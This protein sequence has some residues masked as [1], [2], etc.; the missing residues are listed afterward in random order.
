MALSTNEQVRYWGIGAVVFLLCLWV[1]GNVLLPFIT[2]MA[3]A[4]FL[5]PVADRLEAAGLSR[6]VATTVITLVAVVVILILLIVLIPLLVRQTA[7]FVSALPE[8]V[9][10]LQT[11]IKERFPEAFKEGSAVLQGLNS[12]IEFVRS[13]GGDLANAL[14]ASAFTIVDVAIF[15]VVA[16]VVAFYM[17]LDWDRMIA[18]IDGWIPRDHLETVRDLARQVDNVLAGFVR[19][20]LTVCSILGAFYAVA[21]MLVGLQFGVVVGLIAGLLTF[22]PYVGSIIG[23]VLSIGLALFQFW[24]DPIWIVAVLV[25]FVIGQMLEGNFLTPK[26][27]G[28]SVGL[29][30]VWLMFALS[31]FGS[32]LGF[33]GM[34]IAVPVAAML[35]VFF[36]FGVSQY[37]DGRLYT[38]MSGQKD[39]GDG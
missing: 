3:I 34:L 25:I 37:L 32:F 23:G 9:A 38:G 13:K 14:L 30:P 16:P 36:R 35:G 21:L 6:S 22:I 18:T 33:T 31:A 7:G 10:Q 29:H 2:G 12:V 24:D 39:N 28:R 27:V 15:M 8:Y 19:G 17:L 1:M 5:D 11:F 20:Q 4:Y 26:L